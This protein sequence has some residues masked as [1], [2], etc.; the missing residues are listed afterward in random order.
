VAPRIPTGTSIAGYRVLEL[1][2]EGSS[3][4]VYV[5]EDPSLDRKVAL[6]ILAHELSR[7]PRFRQRF[8]RESRLAASLEHPNIVPI[9]AAGETDDFA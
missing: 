3:G 6:K 2:G 1:I 4:S 7:D 8:L 5:A 9:H